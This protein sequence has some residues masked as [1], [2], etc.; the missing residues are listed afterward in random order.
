MSNFF[1]ICRHTFLDALREPVYSLMLA[2]A[3]VLIYHYPAAALYV[4]YEQF[5]MVTDSALA[6]ILLFSFLVAT[7]SAGAVQAREMRNGT[8]LLLL[9]KPL[10]RKSFL[11]GKMAGVILASELFALT[12][13][14]ATVISLRIATDQFRFDVPIYLGS[15]AVVAATALAGLA[16]N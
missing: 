15:L 1:R 12:L 5:K 2:S 7:L 16:A 4:F 3:V 6:T 11:F 8:V 10:G 14:V 13:A 9:S